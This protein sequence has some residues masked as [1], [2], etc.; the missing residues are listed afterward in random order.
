[1]A[2][3]AVPVITD[4]SGA[5]DDIKDGENGFIVDVGDLAAA[6]E[7]IAYLH[8]NRDTLEKMGKAAHQSVLVKQKDTDQ[9]AFW[10]NLLKE[11]WEPCK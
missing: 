7:R 11:V 10:L 6:A 3:G 4:V 1:M 8:E 5:R 9:K 2:Q